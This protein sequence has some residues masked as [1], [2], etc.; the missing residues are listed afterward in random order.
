MECNRGKEYDNEKWVRGGERKERYTTDF[1]MFK[2]SERGNWVGG[3]ISHSQ[4]W[5]LLIQRDLSLSGDAM[6]C[7]EKPSFN[8]RFCHCAWQKY[9]WGT[10][11]N[12]WCARVTVVWYDNGNGSCCSEGFPIREIQQFV[13]ESSSLWE[14]ELLTCTAAAPWR[15]R[16]IREIH[17]YRL[18][19]FF[20][21]A[22]QRGEIFTVTIAVPGGT[23]ERNIPGIFHPCSPPAVP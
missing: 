21:I 10:T 1:T 9:V 4:P 15:G 8:S 5:Q 13:R 2:T 23:A 14:R 7:A 6:M 18:A 3:D 16:L 19:L 22:L 11:V 20:P 17:S 12:S